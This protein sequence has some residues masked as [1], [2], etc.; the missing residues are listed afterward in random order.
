MATATE[1]ATIAT[2]EVRQTKIL[3][4]GEWRDAVSGKTFQTIN[5]ATEEVIA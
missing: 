2:P 3:I 5:P 1:Q 4:G